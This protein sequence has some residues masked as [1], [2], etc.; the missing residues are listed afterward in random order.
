MI[1]PI[2]SLCV[3]TSLVLPQSTGADATGHA[4]YAAPQEG[5]RQ[6]SAVAMKS[7]LQQLTPQQRLKAQ[8]IIDTY[9]PHILELRES[10]ARK[11]RELA[12]LSYNQTTSPDT[13]PRLGQELQRLRDELQALLL[14]A[15]QQ[16]CTEVG[17]SLGSPQ[18]RGCS[19]EF[20]PS[21]HD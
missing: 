3:L 1:K 7:W 17:V 4:E 5:S 13:L 15:D 19:M 21:T 2:L 14:R 18:S 9:S 11:K 10:I 16:M 20:S 12:L 8:A 6:S